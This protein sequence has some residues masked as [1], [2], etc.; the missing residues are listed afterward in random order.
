M[1]E[2]ELIELVY[3]KVTV[4]GRILFDPGIVITIELRA[5]RVDT[6]AAAPPVPAYSVRGVRFVRVFQLLMTSWPGRPCLSARLNAC[7]TME[8]ASG[9]RRAA[10]H[11]SPPPTQSS[12]DGRASAGSEP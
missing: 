9:R 8:L 1:Q 12:N 10:V 2:N 6:C 3:T 4:L 7:G 5:A 11:Q